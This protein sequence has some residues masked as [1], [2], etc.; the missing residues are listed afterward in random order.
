MRNVG[1]KLEPKLAEPKPLITE[2]DPH[3]TTV[4]VWVADWNADGRLDLIASRVDYQADTPSY[5]IRQHK[6]W[7]YL[8]Q[9][10]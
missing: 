9:A 10:R 1:T 3:C 4:G 2:K 7:V 5:I 6:V 8:R